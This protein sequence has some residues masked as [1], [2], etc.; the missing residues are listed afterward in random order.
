MQQAHLFS[1]DCALAMSLV[2]RSLSL[3]SC[4][5]LRHPCCGFKQQQQLQHGFASARFPMM[6]AVSEGPYPSREF[7]ICSELDLNEVAP[8]VSNVFGTATTTT[9]TEEVSILDD[10]AKFF[11]NRV[12]KKVQKVQQAL[13]SVG[14][15]VAPSPFSPAQGDD[16]VGFFLIS[17]FLGLLFWVGNYMA[18]TWI[19]KDT[20][21]GN[22]KRNKD[23]DG[24]ENLRRKLEEEVD[25]A[26]LIELPTNLQPFRG[27]VVQGFKAGRQKAREEAEAKQ[28]KKSEEGK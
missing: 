4:K 15:S 10:P 9:T 14:E 1:R 17:V 25:P 7:E 22:S 6:R 27:I 8:P 12:E 13:Q 11:Y 19:F 3:S 21:F 16:V 18:P 24:V 26:D 28:R 5:I 23:Y 2:S 20:V